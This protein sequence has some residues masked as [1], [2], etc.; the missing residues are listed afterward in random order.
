MVK[1]RCCVQQ[2]LLDVI[3][4]QDVL[5]MFNDQ[6]FLALTCIGRTG[7][8]TNRGLPLCSCCSF[9]HSC[10]LLILLRPSRLSAVGVVVLVLVSISTRGFRPQLGFVQLCSRSSL[11]P[12]QHNR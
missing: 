12:K 6:I 2:E 9:L 1:E 4:W 8:E 7:T 10:L 5:P 3:H 11:S